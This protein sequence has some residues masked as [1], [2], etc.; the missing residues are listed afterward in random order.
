MTAK[1]RTPS[2]GPVWLPDYNSNVERA[3][4]TETNGLVDRIAALEADMSALTDAAETMADALTSIEALSVAMAAQGRA[5]TFLLAR[6][7]ALSRGMPD[8][9]PSEEGDALIALFLGKNE[10]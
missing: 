6:I 10:D 3:I 8:P 9:R 4:N 1:I 2:T 7:E 5:Q